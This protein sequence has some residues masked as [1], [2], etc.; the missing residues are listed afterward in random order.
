M[1]KKILALLLICTLLFS[2]Y[3]IVTVQASNV[4]KFMDIARGQIGEHGYQNTFTRWYYA[5]D[6]Y[7]RAWCQIFVSWVA[8]WARVDNQMLHSASCYQTYMDFKARGRLRTAASGYIPKKGDIV[9]FDWENNGK[10]GWDHVGIVDYVSGNYL[11]TI[12]GN[13][14][15]TVRQKSYSLNDKQILGYGLP[16][17]ETTDTGASGNTS[18]CSCSTSYAGTYRCTSASVPLK[19]RSGHGVNYSMIGMIPV[20]A[21]NITVTHGNGSW[22]HVTYN[23]VSGYSSMAYLKKVENVTQNP[24]QNTASCTCSTSYAGTYKCTSKYTALKIRSGHGTNYKILGQIPAGASNITVTKANG[25]WAHVTYNG[26]SG[27]SSMGYLTK[28][29]A[30]SGTVTGSCS[31]TTTNA[32]NYKCIS[33]SPLK[34]RSGHGV[35]YSILG[36]IPSGAVVSVSKSN[37]SWA[38]VTYNGVSGYSS[39]AYL[40]KTSGTS[41]QTTCGCT[42]ER[43]GM[44]KCTSTGSALKIR[45]G[46]GVN[47]PIVGTIPGGATGVYVGLS[48]GSWAHVSYNGM[49]GYASMAYLKKY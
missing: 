35:N 5:E 1:K 21:S 20:G 28:V 27:Y 45:S 49:N 29:T 30:S 14:N 36:Q 31:C 7:E 24:T 8:H 32:G 48:N 2:Q 18:V 39:M 3:S 11:Y 26:V 41:N 46:H 13:S 42:Y 33:N 38:H 6:K 16:A 12:E 17:Y 25:S 23:G 19:I 15:K 10:G 43:T 37:G 47:Y 34:I 4:D 44:Y 9:F 40:Q 22:A